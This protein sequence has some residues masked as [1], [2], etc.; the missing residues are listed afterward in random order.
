MLCQVF[1]PVCMLHGQRYVQGIL[2]QYCT[3]F[4]NN[5]ALPFWTIL[6]KTPVL[7]D[8]SAQVF[9]HLPTPLSTSNFEAATCLLILKDPCGYLL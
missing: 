9:S 3:L 2:S 1:T 7:A 4:V 6:C 8:L 5:I